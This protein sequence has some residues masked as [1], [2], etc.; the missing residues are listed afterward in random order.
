M[1]LTADHWLAIMISEE[2]KRKALG[3]QD[4]EKRLNKEVNKDETESRQ[5]IKVTSRW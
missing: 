4:V 3:I 2:L 5:T 1:F